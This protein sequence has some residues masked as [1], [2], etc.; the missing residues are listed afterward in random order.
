M[1][2]VSG[3]TSNSQFITLVNT[4]KIQVQIPDLIEISVNKMM[5]IKRAKIIYRCLKNQEKYIVM[6]GSQ[7][8]GRNSKK[9]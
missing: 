9:V 4:I 1:L 3:E 6:T 5:H 2:V 7:S 8:I